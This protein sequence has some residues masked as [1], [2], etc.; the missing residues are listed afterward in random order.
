MFVERSTKKSPFYN[1]KVLSK[2]GRFSFVTLLL[3]YLNLFS[4]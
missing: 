4:S 3:I 2:L 1:P